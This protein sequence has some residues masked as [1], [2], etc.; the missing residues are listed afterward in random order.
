MTKNIEL[1]LPVYNEQGNIE[2]LFTE[3]E[4]ALAGLGYNWRVLF[5]DDGS[6]DKSTPIIKRLALNKN[7]VSS[8]HFDNNYGQSAAFTAGFDHC[9]SDIVITMDSDRQN[10]PKDIPMMLKELGSYD[11]VIGYR[12]NRQDKFLRK[13]VSDIANKVRN[14]VT[15]DNII[16]TGCSLKVFKKEVVKSLPMFKGMHRFLPTLAKMSGHTVK[17]VPVNH[18]PRTAGTTKYGISDRLSRT[19]FDLAAVYWMKKRNINY[20]INEKNNL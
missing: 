6:N 3:I 9:K 2:T 17:Q 5:V 13:F 18:R 12:H 20:S 8:I 1:I 10:D 16:D 15:D 11:V 14:Y 7:R 19:V 4:Q